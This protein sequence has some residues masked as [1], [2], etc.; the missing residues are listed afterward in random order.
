MFPLNSTVREQPTQTRREKSVAIEGKRA[1]VRWQFAQRNLDTSGRWVSR[2]QNS[3]VG[4]LCGAQWRQQWRWGVAAI[5]TVWGE[6]LFCDWVSELEF[7][8]FWFLLQ[9]NK[10][11][12]T[13]FLHIQGKLITKIGW[14]I[15]EV[16]QI[17]II[18]SWKFP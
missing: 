11:F 15:K 17:L 14:V 16:P 4:S 8:N 1:S 5:G 2:S 13:S 10:R 6:R 9:L 7:S 12:I 18:W 3:T